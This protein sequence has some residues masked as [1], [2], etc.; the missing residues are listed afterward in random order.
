MKL[1]LSY[2]LLAMSLIACANN[3][4]SLNVSIK[5]SSFV[6]SLPA[7]PT[8][9]YQW[10]VV[11]FDKNLLTLSSSH[12]E[13]T[14]TDRIGAGGQMHFIFLLKPSKNYPNNTEIKLN[15]ARPWEKNS[16]TAKSVTVNFVKN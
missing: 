4:Q 9:G 15:Y 16:G 10:S 14:K 5:K 6:V 13:N 8:T 7:N 12:F 11:E 3:D 1:L 2:L